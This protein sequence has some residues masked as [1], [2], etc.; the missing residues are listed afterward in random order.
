MTVLADLVR[1][2]PVVLD[3]P[4]QRVRRG[5]GQQRPGRQRLTRRP[6]PSIGHRAAGPRRVVVHVPVDLGQPALTQRC[7]APTTFG[8]PVILRGEQVE[9]VDARPGSRGTRIGEE[10]PGG[11]GGD[12]IEDEQLIAV[13]LD[14]GPGLKGGDGAA[15]AEDAGHPQ[16]RRRLGL[17]D[18]QQVSVVGRFRGVAAGIAAP[19]PGWCRHAGNCRGT[20][21]GRWPRSRRGAGR[22]AAGRPLAVGC[23]CGR[24]AGRIDRRATGESGPIPKRSCRPGVSQSRVGSPQAFTASRPSAAR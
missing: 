19:R 2:R 23:R 20:G 7:S 10:R 3:L 5:A 16:A 22:A 24:C 6:G 8:Q 12:E 4:G 15:G 11:E 14:L 9:I 21:R 13:D 18:S 1:P 17:D